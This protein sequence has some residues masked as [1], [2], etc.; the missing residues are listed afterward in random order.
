M[1]AL[2]IEMRQIVR[3]QETGYSY[4]RNAS[5]IFSGIMFVGF[6]RL[7]NNACEAFDYPLLLIKWC[8]M[9]R[10]HVQNAGLRHQ[11]S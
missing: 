10:S 6:F 11:N 3:M 2:S 7:I 8:M 5:G 9:I 1:P 4:C